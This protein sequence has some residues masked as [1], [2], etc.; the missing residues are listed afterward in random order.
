M[1]SVVKRFILL[2]DCVTQVAMAW[3]RFWSGL[4]WQTEPPW[5][6]VPTGGGFIN[7]QTGELMQAFRAGTLPPGFFNRD[8]QAI[9]YPVP[10]S[11]MFTNTTTNIAYVYSR[12]I[13]MPH[14]L[15]LIDDVLRQAKEA[16]PFGGKYLMLPDGSHIRLDFVRCETARDFD[17]TTGATMQGMF[18]FNI[19]S[20]TN[21]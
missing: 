20:R 16:I 5:G 14:F 12:R 7:A 3:D 19:R 18:F 2:G 4:E 9:V 1:A 13:T 11:A 15:G 8:N 6:R 10:N 17:D 21:L